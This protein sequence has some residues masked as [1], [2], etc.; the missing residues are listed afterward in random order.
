MNDDKANVMEKIKKL[1]K[2][3]KETDFQGESEKALSLA[4]KLA[5]QIGLSIEDVD[6]EEKHEDH[7]IDENLV[8]KPKYRFQVWERTLANGIADALGCVLVYRHRPDLA[9]FVLIGTKTDAELFNFLYPYIVSQLN[10]LCRQ[11]WLN[12]GWQFGGKFTFERSWYRGAVQRVIMMARDKF[13][14][15]T[16]VDEQQQYALVICNKKNRCEDYMKNNMNV[17]ESKDRKTNVDGVAAHAGY[18]AGGK[19]NF[20]RPIENNNYTKI[21]G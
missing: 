1:L 13:K 7:N 14:Q 4:M 8:Y 3:G 9:C 17:K 10:R 5:G 16:T 6:L 20:N 19:V 15:E 11:D 12:I 2:L 18:V 21:G